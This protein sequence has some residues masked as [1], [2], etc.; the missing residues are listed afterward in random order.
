M[1]SCAAAGLSTSTE[2]GTN[3]GAAM[4]SLFLLATD[5]RIAQTTMQCCFA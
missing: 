3:G 2:S 5:A 1:L 4:Y